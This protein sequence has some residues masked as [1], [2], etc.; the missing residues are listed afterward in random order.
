MTLAVPVAVTVAA[1]GEIIEER[2]DGSVD[3]HGFLVFRDRR[4][5]HDRFQLFSLCR[6]PAVLHLRPSLIVRRLESWLLSAPGRPSRAERRRSLPHEHRQTV[7][8]GGSL[9]LRLCEEV[10][11]TAG[12]DEIDYDL[13][14]GNV[15]GETRGYLNC[16]RPYP[17][18]W[19]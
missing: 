4:G 18:R 6:R 13:P 17:V 15:I 3:G 5:I 16:R 7:D 11:Q 19:R 14:R 2:I 12:V 1:A 10:R 9:C 8:D